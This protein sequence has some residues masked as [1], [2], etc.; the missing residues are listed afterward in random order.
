VS[1]VSCVSVVIPAYCEEALVG[2]TI[3]AIREGLG[4][5]MLEILVV[6]DGS[7]DA[8]AARAVAA[9]ARVI[10]MEVNRGK[11][12]ALTCGLAEAKGEIL[13]LLDADLGASA[14][15][16]TCLVDP[17]A[18]GEAD[19]T[20]AAFPKVAGHKGG[21]G[22]VMR[23]ARWG[24]RQAGGG[25]MGAPLSGQR[26]LSRAAWER[27][28]RLDAGFGI[29]MGLN[30]DAVRSGLRVIEVPTGM[31]HRM[32]GRDWAGFRHRARQFRDVA[33]SILRRWPLGRR[34]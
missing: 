28:G 33:A 15:Q 23:L 27:I 17:I 3:A 12:A 5:Q 22:V 26:A 31:S 16:G 29:E 18:A 30:L 19:M 7:P 6:D 21:F 13:L 20:V 4:S 32:T 2:E 9:G 24:L 25:P 14:S 1:A 34:T 10:R 11:G 8:T